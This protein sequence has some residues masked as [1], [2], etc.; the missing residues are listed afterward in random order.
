MQKLSKT[1]IGKF[2]R[3]Y[4]W[5]KVY[6]SK[7]NLN[8]KN[9]RIH[10][11]SFHHLQ[12]FHFFLQNL[13]PVCPQ[14]APS[15]RQPVVFN[16]FGVCLWFLHPQEI[17]MFFLMSYLTVIKIK[18]WLFSHIFLFIITKTSVYIWD[19]RWCLLVN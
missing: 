3:H 7:K 8:F 5:K 19:T 9:F 16:C 11:Q 6:F 4:K 12:I 14:L 1:F 15:N 18:L 13:D 10:C 2:N 17:I